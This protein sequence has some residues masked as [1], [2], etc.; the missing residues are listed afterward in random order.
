MDINYQ[1]Q[2]PFDIKKLLA[3]TQSK[4]D[5]ITTKEDD[6]LLIEVPGEQTM[7]Y[8]TQPNHPIHPSVVIRAV[9]TEGEQIKIKTTGY[10][11]GDQQR[12]EQWLKQFRQQ[13]AKIKKNLT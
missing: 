9:V 5:V 7:Y 6:L 11:S 2:A 13:D 1:G 8:F 12:F 4:K 10:T 3:E